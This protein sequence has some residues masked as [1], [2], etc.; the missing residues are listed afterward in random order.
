M[1]TEEMVTTPAPAKK[2]TVAK[3]KTVKV[4]GAEPVAKVAKATK[5]VAPRAA[6]KA[7]RPKAE[8]PVEAK[9]IA[10]PAHAEIARL[11]VQYWI[12]RGYEHGQNEQDWYRA[13]QELR[14]LAS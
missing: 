3:A 14:G 4:A 11:A 1:S 5:T 6:A 2:K 12:D 13:E 7:T 8:E 10:V 9:A